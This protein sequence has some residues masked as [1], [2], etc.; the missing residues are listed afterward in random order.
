M[1]ML[2]QFEENRESQKH[3][4]ESELERLGER[5]KTM[6]VRKIVLFGSLASDNVSP[7]S[8]LDLLVVI[9]SCENSKEW[10]RRI[11]DDPDR[12]VACDILVFSEEELEE[13]L[14]A[15]S[16]LRSIVKTGVIVYEAKPE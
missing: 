9:P 7:S 11:Y 16:L 12:V 2:Q 4:L 6:G 15:S 13:N 1:Y 10:R 5:L 8:D 3:L 14:P